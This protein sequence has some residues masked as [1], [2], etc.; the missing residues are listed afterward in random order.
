MMRAM[1]SKELMLENRA[2]KR[3]PAT[4]QCPSEGVKGTAVI[5]HGL[6]GWK[7]QP[8]HSAVAEFFC[9][10]GYAALR[11]NESDGVTSPDGDFFHET[12]TQYTLD[13]EDAIAYAMEQ[14]WFQSP[15]VL[16]GHSMG[17]L[18][19]AWYASEHPQQMGKLILLA[20]A[21]SWKSMWWA[22]L[23]LALLDL[24]RGHRKL[25]GIDGK[26]F[27]LSPLWWKDYFKFDGYGYAPK[28]EVPT[29][30]ISAEKD[31]T[32]AKP[33]EH[34]WYTRRFP[35]AEHSTISWADHDFTGQE[36]EVV[37]TIHQWLTSS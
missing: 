12:T 18:V 32:V 34:R 19:A 24:V 17:G 21:V 30:I 5:F 35:N 20:P 23:P 8:L 28:I 26:K 13:T 29:L 3:M 16:V 27:L 7:D 6:G 22:W 10:E 1:E 37:A 15:L 9:R 36:D 33:F 2:G 11:F 31:H 4:L 25:L 14:S